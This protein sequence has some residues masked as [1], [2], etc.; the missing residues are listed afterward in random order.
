V[1]VLGTHCRGRVALHHPGAAAGGQMGLRFHGQARAVGAR[2]GGD[3]PSALRHTWRAGA[4]SHQLTRPPP[5]DFSPD[6][7]QPP[8]KAGRAAKVL[9]PGRV[10]NPIRG[11]I[12]AVAVRRS[13]FRGRTAVGSKFGPPSTSWSPTRVACSGWGGRILGA[14]TTSRTRQ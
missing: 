7:V 12:A 3:I 10:R 13:W 6:T 5:G 4:D 14:V 11:T 2:E 8:G 1:S 9:C